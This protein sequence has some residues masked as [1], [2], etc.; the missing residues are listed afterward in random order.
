MHDVT[1]SE[2][3]PKRVAALR[4]RGDYAE[5]GATFERVRRIFDAR[6]LW[7]PGQAMIAL[8]HDD[9]AGVPLSE[10][11]GHAGVMVGAEA[12]IHELFDTVVVKGGRHA[13]L[14]HEGS[15]QGLPGAC[16]YLRET[17]PGEAGETPDADVPLQEIY[18]RPPEDPQGALT[19]I[20]MALKP[21]A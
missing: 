11:S 16:R 12:L 8:Y 2:L 20:H 17:W 5:I 10:L 18:L 21:Q 7:A 14:R 1:I 19:E 6:G 13:V 15:Y 9:P 3:P 4:H